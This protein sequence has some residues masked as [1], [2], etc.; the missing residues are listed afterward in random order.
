M[1]TR[2]FRST[3]A[4]ATPS[5]A[6]L[7]DSGWESFRP[8]EKRWA[9]DPVV[10]AEVLFSGDWEEVDYEELASSLVATSSAVRTLART[11]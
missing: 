7:T 10:D 11:A 6:R 8:A 1:K 2:Y 5:L 4:G 9:R 3:V